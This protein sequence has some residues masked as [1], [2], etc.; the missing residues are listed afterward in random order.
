M[1]KFLVTSGSYFKPFTC[2]ELA[3]P[4]VQTVE[5]HNA[6]QDAYDTISAETAALQRYITDNPD[7]S[8]AKEMYDN[9]VSKLTSLQNNLW[10]NGY[11]A[12][13]RRDLSA[14]RAGYFSDITRLATA[15]K[16]RQDRGAVWSKMKMEHP[17]LITS[18]NP[19]NAGLNAYLENENF[20]QDIF[21]YNGKTFMEEVGADVQARGN[22]IL[23]KPEV[24][25]DPDLAGRI[26]TK[27][28]SGFTNSEIDNA[29]SF[30][31][32]VL[33]GKGDM[34]TA[35][36][37]SGAL[38]MI[39]GN[40]SR[41]KLS[42]EEKLLAG[43]LLSRLNATGAAGRVSDSEFNRLVG[44]GE[45][46]M[47]AG[48]IQKPTVQMQ[49]D[50]EWKRRTARE[51]KEWESNLEL[52]NYEEKKKI[53]Q[54]YATPKPGST[55]SGSGSGTV[56][57]SGEVDNS[58]IPSV[59]YV[60]PSYQM[61]ITS[62]DAGKKVK[63]FGEYV[64]KVSEDN[65][66]DIEVDGKP[67]HIT[68]P[69]EA[70]KYLSKNQY[71]QQALRELGIDIRADLTPGAQ[72]TGYLYNRVGDK[73][74]R[75][76]LRTAKLNPEDAARLGPE[77]ANAKVAL[78]NIDENGN[79][80]GINYG[81]TKHLNNILANERKYLDELVGGDYSKYDNDPDDLKK[82]K[83]KFG[84]NDPENKLVDYYKPI[85]SI[86]TERGFRTVEPAP[87]V[88]KASNE[89]AMKTY[90]D[91]IVLSSSANVGLSDKDNRYKLHEMTSA[92]TVSDR[93]HSIESLL[94][95]GTGKAKLDESRALA[96]TATPELLLDG[97]MMLVLQGRGNYAV[98]LRMLDSVLNQ[99]FNEQQRKIDLDG[100]IVTFPSVL[101]ALEVLMEPFRNPEKVFGL[102]DAEARAYNDE[103]MAYLDPSYY[104][105]QGKYPSMKDVMSDPQRRAGYYGD[106][107]NFVNAA[108]AQPREAV[109]RMNFRV[110][111]STSDKAEPMILK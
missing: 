69:K 43:A 54:K 47:T 60:M 63:A 23:R 4:I 26:V 32:G 89:A 93:T 104:F 68:D 85:A 13:T 103:R 74:T 58:G 97:Y 48:G 102:T 50:L 80:T 52:Q 83:K 64:N 19:A 77:Y 11:N 82:M 20:G 18:D 57:G 25:R 36:A 100:N 109:T 28:Q 34:S 27:L 24:M 92:G 30:V 8:M 38:A 53:D 41:V 67:L 7:D 2:D 17:E 39:D 56:S 95:D 33:A 76:R 96:L 66:L 84:I 14:A 31:R 49:E 22:E 12:S 79:S 46:G 99:S 87:L 91:A 62:K 51:D 108:F 65:P 106:I 86:I 6:A 29:K 9:Y 107:V 10:N 15:I 72:T 55:S 73:T 88:T 61:D 78:E 1:P 105:N 5:A 3:K 21:S 70:E 75:T 94:D 37:I 90:V 35:N 101:E 16:T 111:G 45:L 71:Q 59:G 42:T 98:P 44:Y 81:A 110:R 40:D